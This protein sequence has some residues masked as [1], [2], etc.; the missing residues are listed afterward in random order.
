MGIWTR[1]PF[2]SLQDS[3]EGA[4]Q[5][6]REL[7]KWD[8]VCLG[9][10]AIIGAGLF[11]IT[12]IA[13]AEH[14]GPA[15][16]ISFLIAA[17]GCLFTGL[18][19]SELATMFPVAG[20]AYTYAYAAMGQL[21]AWI[22][23]W[24]LLLEYAI[25]TAAVATS[26]SAYLVAFLADFNIKLPTQLIASPWQGIPLQNG[27]VVY[28]WINL[29]A[30]AITAIISGILIVGIKTSSHINTFI[31]V[32]KIAIVLI[33]I[34]LGAFY[35]NSENYHPFIPP[36]TGTF[37]SFGWSGVMR[38]AGML[39]FAYIGFDAVSTAAQE[40]KNPQ[41]DLPIG[42]IG[43]LAISTIL[44]VIFGFVLT[45]LV[46]YR[47]LN[48]ADPVARAIDNTPF[49]WL[50]WL[51]KLA[52]LA[53]L[54]S[55]ILVTMLGQSRILYAM[56]SDGFLPAKLSHLHLRFST[57]W[58]AN[59]TLMLLTGLLA[60]LVPL[61][62]LANMTSIGTLLAF[63]IVCCGVI[64]LRYHSPHLERPFKTPFFP[65]IPL[66]GIMICLIIML[67]LDIQTWYRLLVWLF[68]GLLIYFFY[69]RHQLKLEK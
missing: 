61:E 54:T 34:A 36:N 4:P 69:S 32:V 31:V 65:L 18:C 26:W 67:S 40:C 48:V 59:L 7:K 5:L 22:I 28:G 45:G 33:F 64:F 41:K 9:I 44:Y 8:L 47:E 53:G 25:G 42:I 37:G 43:S 35:I 24:D 15:I 29:P 3:D 52:I 56:A 11:S 13:A 16:V 30:F 6:R 14:A 39:F 38:G 57:P 21:L 12:G 20:S 62:P 46:N 1:K 10:G 51:V 17:L 63:V 49:W 66:L 50:N 55:V 19:Y 23:G 60:A 2:L 27:T 58:Y 68:I